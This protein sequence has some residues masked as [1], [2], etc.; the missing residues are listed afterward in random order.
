M[1]D[2]KPLSELETMKLPL[3]LIKLL[4]SNPGANAAFEE[5]PAEVQRQK[6]E[7]VAEA[8]SAEDR[9]KRSEQVMAQL[10]NP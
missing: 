7:W 4:S 2:D 1:S 6:I 5:L 10:L 8:T 3:Q 9:E